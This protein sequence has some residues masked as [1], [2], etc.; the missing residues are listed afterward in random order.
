M[1]NAGRAIII[2]SILLV[3]LIPRSLSA[4]G[5]GEKKQMAITFDELPAVEAFEEVHPDAINY[6]IL[7]ALKKHGVK[8]TGFVVGS[9]IEGNLDILGQWLQAGHTLG[10]MTF[11]NEDMHN[12]TVDQFKKQVVE[13][14]D[15]LEPMLDGFGQSK[16]YFRFPYLHYGQ[17]KKDKQAMRDFLGS[18]KQILA[19]GTVV[20]EDFTYNNVL[21]GL[22]KIPD[23]TR[24][25][26]LRDEYFNHVLDLVD[27][28][29]L[30]AQRLA[31]RSVRQ[32]LLLKANRLNA[33][34]LDELLTALEESGYGFV[35]LDAALRDDIYSR[36]D[37]YI[38]ARGVGYL[39]MLASGKKK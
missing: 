18:H 16:R 32:I 21:A 39:E 3:F 38:G 8:A 26:Q 15:E 6:L 34:F 13:G 17:T 35:T 20:P 36:V 30:L 23:S 28:E 25:L 2:F 5:K 37:T 14:A 19:H 7:E 11:D 1:R 24:L 29:E 10:S 27:R 4:Q 31:G 22:G 33:I 12:V 9:R